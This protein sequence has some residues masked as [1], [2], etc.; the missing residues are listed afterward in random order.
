[1]PNKP[2]F[3]PLKNATE[4]NIENLPSDPGV[5]GLFKGQKLNY[6]GMVQRNRA[7]ERVKEHKVDE[8]IPF[9]RFGFKAT[10]TKKQAEKIE[11]RL[12]A[13]RKPR[14]NKSGK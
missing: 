4:R 3:G 13:S 7:P 11:A 5:Y 6:V 1:M 8:R 12:I 9:D 2:K 14:Y 10:E